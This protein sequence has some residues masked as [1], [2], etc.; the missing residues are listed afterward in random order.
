MKTF[1]ELKTELL[2]KA[3]KANACRDQYFRVVKSETDAELLTVVADNI[4]WC[5]INQCITNEWL[6]SFNKE[7]ALKAGVLNTGKE[8]TGFMNS[9][10]SNSGDKNSGD[11]NSGYRNSGAFCTDPNPPLILFNK[12]SRLTV[13]EWE[14]HPAY[15]LM[16][17]IA[18]TIWIPAEI[19]TDKEKEEYPIWK[20]V[21]GYL[22]TITLKEA[23]AN[24]WPT[25][26]E[27]NKKHFTTLEN[28]DPEIFK[29][30][31]GID[32]NA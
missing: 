28:F 5:I 2:E 19:M 27:E 22:K 26:S 13:K 16:F 31:T 18:P 7:V 12:A 30:I 29:E 21:E 8:N 23:W 14:N 10:D 11:C 9:G 24:F 1:E 20:T 32:V 3:K 25:L 4:Q 15:R 6:E 17:N